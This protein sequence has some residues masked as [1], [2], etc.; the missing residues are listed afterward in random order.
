[1]ESVN[2]TAL[3]VRQEQA[4]EVV[5]AKP[6]PAETYGVTPQVSHKAA[7]ANPGP[8]QCTTDELFEIVIEVA[9]RFRTA[10][11]DVITHKEYI[12]RLK[13]EVF[14][15]SSGSVGV[16]VPVKYKTKEGKPA[17]KKM[18]WKEF[19][20]TQFGVSADWINRVCGGKAETQGTS[21]ATKP[22]S[23]TAPY[24]H[25]Y[26]AAKA[27]VQMQLNAAAEKQAAVASRNA[28][29]EKE[30]EKLQRNAHQFQAHTQA[31]QGNP[32]SHLGKQLN[33]INDTETLAD[34]AFKIINGTFGQ[35][36]MGSP[37]GIR[38][39]EIAKRA[40]TIKGTIKVC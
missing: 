33:D 24:K 26:E 4:V 3:A 13:N 6:Y 15:V 10:K 25:G 27:E 2:A 8:R 9:R 5:N 30:N 36:L 20:K 18:R 14:K 23:E 37:D 7:S 38:L 1:M 21:R 40:A 11:E 39:V 22:E 12:L 29:L 28:A 16:F 19:C 35:R 34:E 17:A 32:A 31:G